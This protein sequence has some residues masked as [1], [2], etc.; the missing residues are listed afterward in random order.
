VP[1]ENFRQDS[2]GG[3]EMPPKRAQSQPSQEHDES[4]AKSKKVVKTN[5]S[6]RMK[7]TQI[8]PAGGDQLLDLLESESSWQLMNATS[9]TTLTG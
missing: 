5:Y 2:F 4:S 7:K 6:A 3:E 8:K 1:T 9:H